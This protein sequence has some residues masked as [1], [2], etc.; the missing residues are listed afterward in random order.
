MRPSPAPR[1]PGRHASRVLLALAVAALLGAGLWYLRA[2]TDEILEERYATLAAIG[3]LK[4]RQVQAWRAD[5]VADVTLASRSQ[6]IA[7]AL[8]LAGEPVAHPWLVDFLSLLQSRDDVAA[9]LVLDA[10]GGVVDAVGV[11]A[12]VE[13]STLAAAGRARDLQAGT[14]SALF[15]APDGLVYV[16]AVAWTAPGAG[17]TPRVLVERFRVDITLWAQLQNLPTASPSA[18][19]LLVTADGDSVLALSESRHQPDAALRL[20]WPLSD[21]RL[22]AARALAGERGRFVGRDYRGVEVLADLRQVEGTPWALVTKID[23]EEVRADA[24]DRAFAFLGFVVLVAGFVAGGLAYVLRRREAGFYAQVAASERAAREARDRYRTTLYSIGDAVLTTGVDGRVREMNRAAE[25]LTGWSEAEASGRPLAEVFRIVAADSRRPADDPVAA[26][27]REGRVVELPGNIVLLARDGAEHPIADSAAPIRNDAGEVTG[28]VVVVSDQ[29]AA[30]ATRRHVEESEERL[31][32]ALH[33]ANQGLYDL[34]VQTGDAEVSPEYATMLGYDPATFRE[35]NAA[36]IERL[37]PDERPLVA[38]AYADYVEGRLP[39]YRVEFRQ[40]TA[41]GRW[42]WILSL[43][44][45]V[46]RGPNGEPLRML[47]THT[48][49]GHRKAAEARIA[50][51]AQLYATLSQCNSAI[52]RSSS[53]QDLFP[54]VCQAAVEQGGMAMAWVGLLDERSGAVVPAASFGDRYGYLDDLRVSVDAGLPQGRGPAGTAVREGIAQWCQDFAQDPATA[55]WREA[56]ARSGWRASAALPLLRGGRPVGALTLY[57]GS[58]AAFDEEA[59]KLLTSMAADISFALDS[60]AKERARQHAE[61][62]TRAT[63]AHL[64]ATLNAIPDLMFELDLDGRYHDYRA[65]ADQQL[66]LP[67][68]RFLERTVFDVL[69]PEVASVA[70]AALAEALAK[71]WS[72]GATYSLD[73]SGQRRW[74]ELSVARKAGPHVP[75][76]FVVLARDITER[77]TAEAHRERLEAQLR[78]SQKMEAIGQLAGGVAH[79]FNNLLTVI[80]GRAEL[81]LAQLPPGHPLREDLDDIRQAGER[82]ASLTRQLLTFSR[83][84]VVAPQVLSLPDAIAGLRNMLRRLISEDIHLDVRV[85]EATGWVHA[86][87]GQLE[88]VLLNLAVNARDAM[89]TGGVLTIEAAPVEVDAALAA[90]LPPLAAGPHARLTVRDTGVGMD[91]AT[92]ARI[93]E[94]FF[95]TKGPSEGTGLGLSTAY[96]IVAQCGG[97]IL[98]ESAPGQGATFTVYLPSSAPPRARPAHAGRANVPRGAETVLLVDD[99]KALATMASRILTF[100]GYTVLT[101]SNGEEALDVL[102]RHPG[103]VDLLFTDVVIPG[104]SGRELAERIVERVPGIRVLY[105]SGYTED[106]VLVRGVAA[107][108]AH[109]IGKPYSVA[110]LTRK[111]REVLDTRR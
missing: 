64:E 9:V 74:Y 19:T 95:T 7:R 43:G 65:R 82:A 66:L 67:P 33:A 56:G 93:F 48:D 84:Q 32:L 59:P 26:A 61:E 76:R 90:S 81:A 45:I 89:P 75:P 88:Q 58:P 39:E 94:P 73:L 54:Q 78:Q 46:A 25:V 31:R 11:P 52:V 71:G 72:T 49:I 6:L 109:F 36:W 60:F 77:K 110:D 8:A 107:N 91:E 38:R 108:E 105:S 87:P 111:V 51:L 5:L 18:E 24:R 97:T 17:A 98:A 30:R 21:R 103:R 50:R 29:S 16:D 4:S 69:P 2:E 70:M 20:R 68:D 63:R 42:K 12:H 99:E 14:L 13:P 83:R 57:S 41:D 22:A 44:R 104:M 15:R 53:E 106:E 79:D 3:D 100:A 23:Y 27:L 92:R 96:S 37:H 35:T 55:P 80:N 101:A 34:N 40:R 28:V 47:G 62:E 1:L 102:A 10:D 86:D 85:D